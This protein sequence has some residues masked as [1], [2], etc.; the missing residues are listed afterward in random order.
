MNRFS[1]AKKYHRE[2]MIKRF[3]GIGAMTAAIASIIL[4]GSKVYAKEP[5]QYYSKLGVVVGVT[6]D[7]M[8]I[9]D[10]N[11]NLWDVD[12][13]PEDMY[14]YDL[15]SMI[16]DTNG[17]EEIYDDTVVRWDYNGWISAGEYDLNWR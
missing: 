14:I 4:L 11:G 17:T 16:M 6:T 12:Y 13:N 9:Q 5:V 10:I 7:T 15:V 2:C 8:T 3:I 1:K